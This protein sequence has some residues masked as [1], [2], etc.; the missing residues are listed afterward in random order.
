MLLK[1]VVVIQL[2]VLVCVLLKAI[3]VLI[4]NMYPYVE[5]LL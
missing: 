3:C 5:Y 4:N 2:F 1:Y